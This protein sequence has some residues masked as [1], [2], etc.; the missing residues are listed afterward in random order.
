MALAGVQGHRRPGPLHLTLRVDDPQPGQG[1]HRPPALVPGGPVPPL[2]PSAGRYLDGTPRGRACGHR[3][4]DRGDSARP[5]MEVL[6]KTKLCEG[7]CKLPAPI[8]KRTDRSN[9]RIK[10]QPVRFISGH[11]ARVQPHPDL[12]ARYWPKVDKD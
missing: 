6:A 2:Q 5:V 3:R 10:G 1:S 12:T 4:P 8:A 9:G 11:Y 7:G